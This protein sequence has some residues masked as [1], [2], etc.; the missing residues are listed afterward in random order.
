MPIHPVSRGYELTEEE[1]SKI[2]IR[3]QK[4]FLKYF[5]WFL[6]DAM[7]AEDLEQELLLVACETVNKYQKKKP[8]EELVKLIHNRITW[9]ILELTRNAKTT[10]ERFNLKDLDELAKEEILNGVQD[11][12]IHSEFLKLAFPH[13]S[14]CEYKLLQQ[15][16][17]DGKTFGELAKI[18]GRSKQR[19]EQR[20]SIIMNRLRQLYDIEI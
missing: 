18:Y 2:K 5:N 4:T 3:G 9:K 17:I 16:F 1:I 10:A 6:A 13:C 20:Y 7:S 15:K 19:I 11:K 12:S 14:A 8:A